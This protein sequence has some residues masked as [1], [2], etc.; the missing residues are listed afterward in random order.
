M[1][2]KPGENLADEIFYRQKIPDLRYILY[3]YIISDICI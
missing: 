1:K 3:M 2:I